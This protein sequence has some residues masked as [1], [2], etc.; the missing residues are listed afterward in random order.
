MHA[1]VAKPGSRVNSPWLGPNSWVVTKTTACSCTTCASGLVPPA[2]ERATARGLSIFA[3]MFRRTIPQVLGSHAVSRV[4]NVPDKPEPPT[5]ATGGL[6]EFRLK[7]RWAT[8]VGRNARI[9]SLPPA[10][11]R[12]QGLSSTRIGPSCLF[13]PA[14]HAVR[15]R[16]L[17]CNLLL[18]T[19]SKQQVKNW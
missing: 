9:D 8:V 17:P 1:P 12:L 11:S 6:N 5:P 18:A 7:S 10:S 14:R 13:S 19:L 15:W 4:P 2:Q 16:T 3:C